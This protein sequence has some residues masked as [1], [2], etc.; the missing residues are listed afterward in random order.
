MMWKK[1]S[2]I[3]LAGVMA[4][5]TLAGCQSDSGIS[6]A[7]T[8]GSNA[9]SS[10]NN[11][12]GRFMEEEVAL[13]DGYSQP[14]EVRLLS[15]GTICVLAEKDQAF[16][17]LKSNDLC[18]SWETADIDGVDM[19]MMQTTA[20]AP[21]GGAAFAMYG[22][23][24]DALLYYADAEGSLH[25]L[26]LELGADSDYNGI[27]Q[28]QF[29]K[30][31][32]LFATDY[33]GALLKIDLADGSFTQ[34]FDLEENF[35]SYFGIAGN[36]L[37]AVCAQGVFLFDTETGN[38]L[39]DE[40]VLN[41]LIASDASLRDV[42]SDAGF[43]SVF[44][45]S[46]QEN[47]ILMAYGDGIFHMTAGGSVKE[48]LVDG[49]MNSLSAAGL[50]FTS[51]AMADEDHLFLTVADGENRLLCYT[52]D[53]TASAVPETELT[54]YSLY[55]SAALHQ[56]ITVF[57]K[58][59]PDI[60]VNLEIGLS[61]DSGVTLEDALKALSTEILAGQGPDVLV[62][63]DMPV[64]SYIEK[65]ILT[66]L[67]DLVEETDGQENLFTNIVEGSRAADGNIY[68][69]PMRF[70]AEFV[71]GDAQTVEAASSLSSLADRAKQLKQT[72]DCD[73]VLPEKSIETLLYELYQAD[74]A[75]WLKENGEIDM[76][77]MEAYFTLAKQLY[78]IDGP[79]Q[80]NLSIN[81]Y[82]YG[83]ID[84]WLGGT[85]STLGTLA[86]NNMLEYGTLVG[87][88]DLQLVYSVMARTGD[89]YGLLNG[90]DTQSYI[91][92]LQLG[93]NAS[94]NVDNAKAFVQTLLKKEAQEDSN[95][96]PVNRA[97]YEE[98]AQKKL[99]EDN[100]YSLGVSLQGSDDA[101]DMIELDYVTLTQEQIDA[102]T[103][104]LESLQIPVLTD[105]V[106]RNLVLEQGERY[107]SGEQSLEDTLE[108]VNKKVS[109]YLAE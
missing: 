12:V 75:S 10:E 35:L 73:R 34:P 80:Q 16:A 17:L 30:N 84:G 26:N 104:I 94:G 47:G 5:T 63:D 60:Y 50:L 89:T 92:Y 93:V 52:Y 77:K 61:D 103:K 85:L 8:N 71:L 45:A 79:G 49:S 41:D 39:E 29:D 46:T 18:K 48:Q 107:L 53:E 56:G 68:A 74:S 22:E 27:W 42:S 78:D 3:I 54:V 36:T 106:V 101:R 95:G 2:S 28:M 99:E 33:N 59:N 108:Q 23:G 66:D 96:F 70:F 1:V 31:G 11:A 65:G 82:N 98:L 51:L 44:A 90:G 43:P 76:D 69:M 67:S 19:N 24:T 81:V 6:T 32:T 64:T 7:N 40:T 102:C 88:D 9:A 14:R 38:R 20:I 105:G 62:L 37:L 15:D 25:Q 83:T 86:K 91:P 72:G 55:D 57:Q 58:A 4:M 100:D 87:L 13:P 97:A 109:L 21:D